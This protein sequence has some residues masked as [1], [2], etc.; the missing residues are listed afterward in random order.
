MRGDWAATVTRT[1]D[2][3]Y[4]Q[5][6]VLESR[7]GVRVRVLYG[8]LWL[9]EEGLTQDVFAACG[10]EV[11]LKSRG[12]AVVEGLGLARVQVIEPATRVPAALMAVVRTAAERLRD[13]L[14]AAGS[15]AA[16]LLHA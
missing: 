10:E 7:P 9:T 15:A 6:L 14:R 4:E 11:A 8:S 16:R 13:R 3:G 2:L 5:L 12:L 1:V